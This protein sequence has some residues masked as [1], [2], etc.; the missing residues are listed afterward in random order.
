MIYLGLASLGILK[1]GGMH[2]NSSAVQPKSTI[3]SQT[4]VIPPAQNKPQTPK[5]NDQKPIPSLTQKKPDQKL[6]PSNR[7]P[8][9]HAPNPTNGQSGQKPPSSST[10]PVSNAAAI[11]KLLENVENMKKS[12]ALSTLPSKIL[13]LCP[14]EQG[15]SDFTK[16][17]CEKAVNDAEFATLGAQLCNA[18]WMMGSAALL[19]T[20]LLITIQDAYKKRQQLSQAKFHGLTVFLC[21]LYGMLTVKGQTLKP[22]NKPVCELLQELL[23]DEKLSEDSIFYFFQ[24]MEKIGSIIEDDNKVCLFSIHLTLNKLHVS[25]PWIC[26]FPQI[27][28]QEFYLVV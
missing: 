2:P 3:Q 21:E 1:P 15:A 8:A 27:V 6:F 7:T 5:Q 13:E 9:S 18:C 14:N 28:D 16:I 25:G 19:R 4:S 10:T 22:L 26:Q 23:T 20:P 24:E 12:V 17:I 11:S